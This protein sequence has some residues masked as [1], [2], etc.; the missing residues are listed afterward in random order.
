MTRR[1]RPCR[2][3]RLPDGL[4]VVLA[5]YDWSRDTV[6]ESGCRVYR[7]S[8]GARAGGLYVKHGR[9]DH[10][11]DVAAEYARLGW[12]A[13]RMPVPRIV[14]YQ[15][16]RSGAW[17]VTTALLGESAWVRLMPGGA[18]V[19]GAEAGRTVDAIADQLRALHALPATGCPFTSALPQRLAAARARI[20]AGLVDEEDFDEARAGWSA[21]QVWGAIEALLPH[22][23]DP[24]DP[25]VVTHGDYSLDN[26]LMIGARVTG[27]IDVGR[28]GLADRYQ[29]LAIAWNCLAE[30]GAE[31][32]ARFLARYGAEPV[33]ERRLQL[34]LL[35]DELF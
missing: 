21:E 3:P 9:G 26:I 32:Q 20:D 15:A 29:D 33:D 22:A 19:G 35:L 14:H 8:G 17:L 12:L 7:L 25:P 27:L 34:H 4:A 13:G 11:A 1:D 30:F 31:A 6:G 2:A 18:G 24:A 5:G 10:A 23:G 28:V 16:D